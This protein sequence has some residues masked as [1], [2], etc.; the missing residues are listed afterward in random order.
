MGNAADFRATLDDLISIYPF[1]EY[2]YIISHLLAARKLS[3]EEY[4]DLRNA[5]VDRNLYL[6]IF[7]ISAPRGLGDKW[8]FGHLK[9]LAPD[10][11]RPAKR[12]DPSHA[13]DYDFWLG[14]TDKRGKLSGI[15]VEVKTSRAVD[16]DKPDEPL[17]VKALTSDSDRPFDMNFQ[18]IKP[19]CADI[20]VWIGVWRDKL[21]YWVL[22]SAEVQNDK[23][24]SRGQHR[25]NIGEGQLHINRENIAHFER[26]AVTST[27]LREAM[28]NAYKRQQKR[29]AR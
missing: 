7:E 3:L 26:Y 8:T 16:Q 15:R 11:Q 4:H 17:Y 10:L 5:Y 22:A 25:G 20:F 13:N 18:Q 29:K 28:L 27:G 21:R 9:E 1:S 2:E 24:F 6:Y 19:R 14:W 12:L 23:Y